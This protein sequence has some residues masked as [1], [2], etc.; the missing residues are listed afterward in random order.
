MRGSLSLAGRQSRVFNHPAASLVGLCPSCD[1]WVAAV[2]VR[3]SLLYAR[4]CSPAVVPLG[5]CSAVAQQQA[6]GDPLTQ[7][8][9]Y[10]P[11]AARARKRL[12]AHKILPLLLI[13]LTLL[14][15]PATVLSAAIARLLGSLRRRTITQK[16]RRSVAWIR[17]SC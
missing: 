16:D 14:L 10:T 6:A 17:T 3:R 1:C 7:S 8:S 2:A 11:R 9:D 13:L 15:L 12:R 4:C 5:C